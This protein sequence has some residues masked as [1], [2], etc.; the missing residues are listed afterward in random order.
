MI[1]K[2][3]TPYLA[4]FCMSLTLTGC[5]D[6]GSDDED[7]TQTIVDADQDSVLDVDDNCINVANADQADLDGDGAGDVCDLDDDGD[8]VLDVEDAFPQ[9]PAESSD[10]DF[11]GV[12]DNSDPDR[13]GDGVNNEEDAFPN[14][15]VESVDT[16]GDGIGNVADTDDDGDGIPDTED[17]TPLG[18]GGIADTDGDGITDDV[19]TDDDNDGVLDPDDAFPLDDTE[20]V[21]T[22]NDGTG[23]NA[24]AD[25][26]GDGV[27]DTEDDFPLDSSEATDTDNDGTGNNADTDDDNDGVNDG[28]DAFP[29]DASETVDTDGDE[30]GN[31][32]DTDD[33]GD[34]VLDGDDFYPLDPTRD[35]IS[36]GGVKG[37]MAHATVSL[38]QVDY[39]AEDFKGALV[40]TG[41]TD[42]QAKI[43]GINIVDSAPPF[44]LIIEDDEDTIDITTGEEPVIKVVK[45]II[46]QQMLDNGAGWYATPLSTMAVNIALANATNDDELLAALNTAA[47]QVKSTLG[48]GASDD[49]N[50]YE[51]PPLLDPST[52]DTESQVATTQYRSAV[53]ALTAVVFQMNE[54]NNNSDTENQTDPDSL[55]ASLSEDLSDGI[56][57]GSSDGQES[58]YAAEVLEV[59][60]QD[61]ATLP[62]PNDPENRTVAQVK[63]VIVA[64]TETTGED[65][66]TQ[67]LESDATVIRVKV[68]ETNPDKDGDGVLN[69]DDAFP[70]DAS[71]DSDFDGDG[72]PDVAFFLD[73]DGNR[74][75]GSINIASSDLDDDNDGVADTSDAF[76]LDASEFSDTDGDGIGDNADPDRDNDGVANDDDAFPLNANES[77][78]ADDDGIGDNQDP[79]D[80]NDGVG[81]VVDAFPLN[82]SEFLDTDGD[83]IGNNA[84]TDDDGDGTLDIDDDFPLDPGRQNALDQ[85]NDGWPAEQD[86]DDNDDTIPLTAFVDSDG[87]K[88]ADSNDDDDDNDGILDEDDAFPFDNSEHS[89]LDGDGIGD[90][91]DIDIDGDGISNGNDAFPR[92]ILETSDTD[93]DGVGNNADSDDDN[94]G[95]PDEEDAFPLNS[96]EQADFDS[97]GLG[98]RADPDDDDDGVSDESDLFPFNR[99]EFADF[100][101]D[102]TGDNADEDDDND[103]LSDALEES[104]GTNPK[105]ID[106]DDDGVLD[107]TDAFPTDPNFSFDT[108]RDG[109][110]NFDVNGNRVDNCPLTP[111]SDQADFD[112]DQFGDAC[113][114]DD[115][116]DQVLDIDDLFPRN[117]A[118]SADN[119]EDGIGDN[120]DTDDDNDGV[121]DDEDAFDFDPAEFED[122]DNDGIGNNADDDDDGDNVPDHLDVFPLDGGE[123]IDSDNDGIGDNQD[124]DDDND[125]FLDNVDFAPFDPTENVDTDGDGIGDNEDNDD[126]GDGINDALDEDPLDGTVGASTDADGDGWPSGQDPNDND[127]NIP[128]FDYS[129]FDGDGLGD[130]NGDGEAFDPDQ[131]NDG[132]LNIFDD[133]PLNPEEH[134]DTD[135]DGIGNNEDTDDDGDGVDDVDDLFPLN[136]AESSDN[137][138]DGIPDGIDPDDDNDGVAD[139]FDDFQFDPNEFNDLDEDGIGDN[140]D[141]DIDGD[142]VLNE[143]DAFPFN[144]DFRFDTDN[145]GIAD[146]EDVDRDNDGVLN[147]VDAFP[148]DPSE[149]SD[150][151]NDGIGDNSDE[152][153]D[154]DN[155]NNDE[156]DQPRNPNESRDSDSDGLGDNADLDDDND[157]ILD[158]NDAEPLNPDA[159]DDGFIDGLDSCPNVANSEQLDFDFDGIGDACDDDSDN[160]T[161]LDDVDNCKTRVNPNQDDNDGDNIGDVCDPDDDNDEIEDFADNCPLIAN[162][163]QNNLDFDLFGDVCDEDDDNDTVVDEEDNCPAFPNTQQNNLDGDEFGDACDTDIDG[164]DVEDDIDLNPFDPDVGD[165]LDIDGDTIEDGLDNCP[166]T[167]NEDQ[168][169][170]NEDGI[171][172]ACQDDTDADDDGVDDIDDNCPAKFND[173]QSDVDGDGIGDVCDGELTDSDFDGVPDVALDGTEDNC[174]LHFNPEQFDLDED[175][176]GDACDFDIDNDGVANEDDNCPFVPNED[177]AEDDDGLGLACPMVA[178]D[179]DEDGIPDEFDN[180]FDVA[181]PGQEDLD[182]DGIGDLCDSAIV[183][184]SGTWQVR[185]T[186]TLGHAD[187]SASCEMA[188]EQQTLFGKIVEVEIFGSQFQVFETLTAEHHELIAQGVISDDFLYEG[189]DLRVIDDPRLAGD[190]TVGQFFQGR[191][192]QVTGLL[193][194]GGV[195]DVGE[196]PGCNVA[197]EVILERPNMDVV[198]AE[199]FAD[200]LSWFDSHYSGDGSL[201]FEYSTIMDKDE[202]DH[203]VEFFFDFDTKNW[204][205]ANDEEPDLEYFISDNGIEFI[206]ENLMITGYGDEGQTAMLTNGFENFEA[207]LWAMPLMGERISDFLGGEY[208]WTLPIDALFTVGAEAYIA[209][210]ISVNESYRFRCDDHY[211]DWFNE[212]LNCDNV[213]VIDWVSDSQAANDEEIPV[214]AMVMD[215]IVND[216]SVEVEQPVQVWLDE[217]LLIEIWSDDGTATGDNLE[218]KYFYQYRSDVMPMEDGEMEHMAFAVGGITNLDMGDV[219]IF[220]LDVPEGVELKHDGV[221]FFFEESGL[222]SSEEETL[223]LLR[224][225]QYQPGMQHQQILLFNEVARSDVLTNFDPELPSLNDSDSDGVIDAVDNCPFSYNP[226]QHDMDGDG[227]GDVCDR[228][229]PPAEDQDSD[230]DGWLDFEDNC[231]FVENE[232][233]MDEN[234]NGLGD[235]CEV[236]GE[237]DLDGDGVIDSDDEDIDGD[238]YFNFEDADLH[239]PFIW[240]FDFDGDGIPDHEDSDIDGDGYENWNDIE[241]FNP[242]V[243]SFEQISDIDMDGVIDMEDNCVII[244]NEDQADEDEDG[245]GDACDVEVSDIS[246][247]WHA[248]GM[249]A[250]ESVSDDMM[251]DMAGESTPMGGVV[252]IEMMGNQFFVYPG[253]DMDDDDYDGEDYHDDGYHDKGMRWL[254]YG[255]LAEDNSYVIYDMADKDMHHDDHM[256]DDMPPMDDMGDDNPP[257]DDMGDGTHDDMMVMSQG[258]YDVETDSLSHDASMADPGMPNCMVTRGFTL[259]RPDEAVNEE[260]VLMDGVSWFEADHDYGYTEYEYGM[261]MDVAE[262]ADESFFFYDF[263]VPGWMMEMDDDEDME[264]VIGPDGISMVMDAFNVDGYGEGGETAMLSGDGQSFSLDLAMIDLSGQMIADYLPE[265]YRWGLNEDDLFG[266]DAVGYVGFAHSGTPVYH[267]WCDDDYDMWFEDNLEC[268]NVVVLDWMH[269]D[270]TGDKEPVLAM[271]IDDVVNNRNDFMDEPAGEDMT[272]MEEEGP[273]PVRVWINEDVQAEIWSDDGTAGGDNLVVKYMKSWHDAAGYWHF[274]MLG[275]GDLIMET[276]GGLMVYRFDIPD[277]VPHHRGGSPFLFEEQE[278]DQIMVLRRGHF[279][280]GLMEHHILFGNVA[281]DEILEVFMPEEAANDDIDGDGVLDDVDNCPNHPNTDQMDSDNNGTGDVCE[282]DMP[283]PA[284]NDMD[285]DGVLDDVDNCPNHPNTDQMDSDNNGVGDI[286]EAA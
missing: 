263:S 205:I 16:D 158:E 264:Y 18:E 54:L 178:A 284:D 22:D 174:V 196:L 277:M 135:N 61:P 206:E 276:V 168:L 124:T 94:D 273:E 265:P 43:V 189:I 136:S 73:G 106:S 134:K 50:I 237:S 66:D 7:E 141:P 93:G 162:E 3:F 279:R 79:D 179:F 9:N 192:N 152:D 258:M 190:P 5:F 147:D 157:G 111:N 240:T 103:G 55:L 278:L 253:A 31:N 80:D 232:D 71:A 104:I 82:A 123:A 203:E 274:E 17:P 255:V 97:D 12:G 201:E 76:P 248:T 91:T 70:E 133:F 243:W 221:P 251:C 193:K 182:R 8:S 96:Q 173:D 1:M 129:D 6:F 204:L 281:K 23:N 246:G 38:Y 184:L 89:D 83:Q 195:F 36:G 238:G 219:S 60:D 74:L 122:T 125:G 225:G 116:N 44:L 164:D 105:D 209:N 198:E 267:F 30:I 186:A 271:S 161:I 119:D 48:F 69:S 208:R 183:D 159:D 254:A 130:L 13:D 191:Y 53:E 10:I 146:S 163:N 65:A 234:D 212:N 140:S 227:F 199:S 169:D 233:Q 77:A 150:L 252:A 108:D 235:V 175:G 26:D 67:D 101:G 81:D 188:G 149:F 236:D 35:A 27:N 261:L 99:N 72:L 211:D 102:G 272:A 259:V 166:F 218:V 197:I 155:V 37:P 29:L 85:D 171:G 118:E 39:S 283:P 40:D 34:G 58:S 241:P 239:N 270:T 177:Q 59:L 25:D 207:E 228:D 121:P 172:D 45:T 231:P 176:T 220:M 217:Y 120:A 242:D 222:E 90:N 56:I 42:A 115:D 117:S 137:D 215:D 84:D 268:D 286:C 20:S 165:I 269:D 200:G 63:A 142:D 49:V 167:S 24:D 213:I 285:G 148:L 170:T 88:I 151:D 187:T 180:C 144:A 107:R 21:D 11:D 109:S 181:N 41:A 110:A 75:T 112:N 223:S 126:D 62:I 275:E 280:E 131:D 216:A 127:E 98:N 202:G 262:G 64:E 86:P 185:S 229:L 139:Q 14:D 95:V 260:T 4:I 113:D 214:L 256:G 19:D 138:Q 33:D 114:R 46:T 15:H 100:D 245:L 2:R 32:A 160:D 257:M 244:A 51:T 28:E 250:Y 145:D 249:K 68:A 224:R 154:G 226:E 247:V 194:H 92:N 156:D 52:E 153:I 143:E 78:D 266:D 282:G 210:V 128:D 132:I 87:D 47:S 57:D 230:Q